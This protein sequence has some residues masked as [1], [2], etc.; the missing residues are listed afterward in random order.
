MSRLRPATPAD[1][2][3][4]AALHVQSRAVHWAFLPPP[5]QHAVEQWLREDLLPHGGTWILHDTDG[6][7]GFVSLQS[8]DDG[9]LWIGNLYVAADR[10][11]RGHGSAPLSFALSPTQRQDRTVRL[12]TLQGNAMGRR[13]YEK[14][15]FRAVRST[16]GRA[17]MERLP[18]VLYELRPDQLPA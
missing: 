17:N 3:A 6:V 10:V 14:H 11:R 4:L 2:G 18:D 5:P 16:D 12:W 13:F 15:G 7:L 9:A 8:H 1:A